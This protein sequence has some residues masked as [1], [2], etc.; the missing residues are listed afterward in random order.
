[1]NPT[2]P[3]SDLAIRHPGIS[4]GIGLGFEEAAR[5]CL[6]RHHSSPVIFDIRDNAKETQAE[7]T[8]I[9]AGKELEG[10]WGNEIDATEAGA[11]ALALATVELNRG[12]VA[13]RRAETRSGADYYVDA[14][15]TDA[16]DLETAI[17]LE[18]SGTSDTSATVL[19]GRLKQKLA[20]T[21]KGASNLPAIA[22]VVGFAQ[23]RILAADLT[24]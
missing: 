15:G 11:C 20:Q 18:I 8:W 1:M 4:D 14:P 3:F 24:T 23:S 5:V 10:A 2:L 19:E 9:P 13:I 17:R 6:D 22:T 16:N 12:L 21:A 7:L